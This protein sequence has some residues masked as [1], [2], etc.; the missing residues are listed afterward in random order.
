M[1]KELTLRFSRIVLAMTLGIILFPYLENIITKYSDE[2]TFTFLFSSFIITIVAVLIFFIIQL[3]KKALLNE[4][5]RGNNLLENIHYLL[6]LV[7]LT[8]FVAYGLTIFEKFWIGLI[9]VL[10]EIFGMLT[11]NEFERNN[12]TELKN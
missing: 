10:I 8:I 12:K 4:K 7:L 9:L 1:K 2:L 5:E 11:D 6:R 3:I